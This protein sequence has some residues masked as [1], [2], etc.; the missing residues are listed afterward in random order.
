MVQCYP[1]VNGHK[2]K[3]EPRCKQA[4]FVGYDKGSSAFLVYHPADRK[5]KRYGTVKF[6]SF[7]K[8]DLKTRN[9]D[10]EDIVISEAEVEEPEVNKDDQNIEAG[11]AEKPDNIEVGI[12]TQ[13]E[14]RFPARTH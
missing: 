7:F 12:E 9:V 5:V 11:D 3:L 2:K 1:Y 10:E 8:R 6:T 14:R 13:D 4:I